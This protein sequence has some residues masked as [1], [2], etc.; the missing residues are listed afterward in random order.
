[1]Q[2]TARFAGPPHSF[3]TVSATVML[4]TVPT[5][6]FMA[7]PGV[8]LWKLGYAAVPLVDGVLN[9]LTLMALWAAGKSNLAAQWPRFLAALLT[10]CVGLARKRSFHGPGHPAALAA[11]YGTRR[12]RR[13]RR[14]ADSADAANVPDRRARTAAE[15][16]LDVQHLPLDESLALLRVRQLRA[17]PRPSLPLGRHL[18]RYVAF[19]V[20]HTYAHRLPQLPILRVL[21]Y[22]PLL[23]VTQRTQAAATT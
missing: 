9:A 18:H 5:A 23:I 1:V 6:V 2:N 7:I 15:A 4:I 12:S 17:R 22:F 19:C 13:H 20:R 16:V 8:N 14:A 10:G 3:K 21:R 11:A